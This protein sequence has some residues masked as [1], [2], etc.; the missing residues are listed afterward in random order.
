MCIRDR[1][2]ELASNHLRTFTSLT[3]I[4]LTPGTRTIVSVGS[5]GAPDDGPWPRY[6]IYD[7][8]A[9]LVLLRCLREA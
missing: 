5:A 7:D 9:R 8:A 2:W 1:V 4:Q 3:R 6:A